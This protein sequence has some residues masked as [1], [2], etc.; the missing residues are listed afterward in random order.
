MTQQDIDFIKSELAKGVIIQEETPYIWA[1]FLSFGKPEEERI[2]AHDVFM[3]IIRF[4]GREVMID[5]TV[6]LGEKI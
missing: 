5:G 2:T 1:D 3:Q 6:I 4:S